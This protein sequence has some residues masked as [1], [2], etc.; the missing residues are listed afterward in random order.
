MSTGVSSSPP[1]HARSGPPQAWHIVFV[2]RDAAL[3][4]AREAVRSAFGH[5]PVAC[6]ELTSRQHRVSATDFASRSLV[7]ARPIAA[8]QCSSDFWSSGFASATAP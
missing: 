3:L 8:S 1:P 5:V 2:A 7:A 4:I 6:P